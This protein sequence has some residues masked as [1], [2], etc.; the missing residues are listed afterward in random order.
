MANRARY[1][2]QIDFIDE[3]GGANYIDTFSSRQ[4]KKALEHLNIL[5]QANSCLSDKTYFVLDKYVSY[6]DEG[7]DI[8]VIEENITD[9]KGDKYYD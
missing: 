8:E 7:D 6:D 4:R 3:Q 2:Y 5:N 1:Y 9:I